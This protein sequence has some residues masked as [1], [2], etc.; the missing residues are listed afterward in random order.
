[1]QQQWQR[2]RC[3]PRRCLSGSKYLWGMGT[4]V[5]LPQSKSYAA[6]WVGL[7]PAISLAHIQVIQCWWIRP[8]KGDRI[9]YV[10][11]QLNPPSSSP[12]PPTPHIYC[13]PP[14]A[15]STPPWPPPLLCCIVQELP[16]LAD[17][18]PCA[19]TSGKSLAIPRHCKQACHR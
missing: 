5:P 9:W 15:H 6:Q 4:F 1:M 18:S 13:H 10:L 16:C 2:L 8:G 14:P 3:I 17:A 12:N 11:V 19:S 7:T